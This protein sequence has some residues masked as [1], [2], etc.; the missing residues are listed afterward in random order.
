MNHFQLIVTTRIAD[1]KAAEEKREAE[2]RERIRAEEQAKA[3]KAAREKVEAEQREAAAAELAAAKA[4]PEGADLS[5]AA[6][7]LNEQEGAARFAASH[8]DLAPAAAPIAPPAVV[9]QAPAAN[10]PIPA[11]NVVPMVQR[12][13]PAPASPPTLTLGRLNERL[14]RM[15]VS[16]EDLRALGFEPAGRDRSAVLFHEA[17]F[18]LIVEAMV[19]HLRTVADQHQRQVA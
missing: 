18:P 16:A 13:A 9:S 6:Q 2:T 15:K 4:K 17:Q 11:A 7:A 5:P 1:H 3:E 14:G 12:Q 19:A 8:R 10:S